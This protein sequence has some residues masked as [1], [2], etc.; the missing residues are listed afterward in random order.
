MSRPIAPFRP[1]SS[2]V[3]LKFDHTVAAQSE[4]CPAAPATHST[5]PTRCSISSL[6]PGSPP[7]SGFASR[8]EALKWPRLE[9]QTRAP[10]YMRHQAIGWSAPIEVTPL[11]TL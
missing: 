9:D 7:N 8:N 6:S 11:P 10:S 1:V 4:S 3:R 5:P 2:T